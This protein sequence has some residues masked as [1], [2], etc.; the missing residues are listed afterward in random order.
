L[1]GDAPAAAASC[2]AAAAACGGGVPRAAAPGVLV[3]EKLAPTPD[4]YPRRPGIP[5]KRP[6]GAG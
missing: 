4:R 3:V 6:I 2:A 1:V 5:S